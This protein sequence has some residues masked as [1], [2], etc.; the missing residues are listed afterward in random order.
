[1]SAAPLTSLTPAEVAALDLFTELAAHLG[2]DADADLI[3]QILAPSGRDK[4]RRFQGSVRR[5]VLA[6]DGRACFYCGAAIPSGAPVHLDHVV[7]HARGGRTVAR[8]GVAACAPCNLKKS[9]KV[10]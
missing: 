5:A 7:P 1:M 3:A 10:W 2:A 9:A 8:N 6:R 4:R